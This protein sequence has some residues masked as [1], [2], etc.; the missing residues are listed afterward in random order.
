MTPHV[1]GNWAKA[2]EAP[3]AALLD[4]IAALAPLLAEGD[5]VRFMNDLALRQGRAA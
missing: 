2:E 4:D 3:L 1:L 5:A